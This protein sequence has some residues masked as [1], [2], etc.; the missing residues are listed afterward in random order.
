M[1]VAVA[2]KREQVDEHLLVALRNL[3]YA[4]NE[5]HRPNISPKQVYQRVMRA[6]IAVATAVKKQAQE[7]YG[8]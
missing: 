8:P 1:E 3:Q 4:V 5:L 2:M 6:R 7:V